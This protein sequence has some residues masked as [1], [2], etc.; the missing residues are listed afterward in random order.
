MKLIDLTHLIEPGMPVF[1]GTESPILMGAN[2]VERNGF[3]EKKLTLYSHTG[4]HMDAPAHMQAGGKTLD[5]YAV[6]D[7]FGPAVLADFSRTSLQTIESEHLAPYENA[8]RQAQFLILRT[9][10]AR[11]W[12]KPKYFAQFPALSPEAAAHVIG[13]G[14]KGVGIDAISIDHMEDTHFPVHHL[15]FN[16][17]M[18]II[19][20]LTHLEQV[21]T[22]FTLGCFPMLIQDA[23]GAPARAV[24]ILD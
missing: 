2:T 9:G 8:L 21:T 13:L 5:A 15:F 1:P 11:H 19:E 20:N 23:D 4:T 12:G 24:A 10:W 22:Q 17:G 14:I 16:A 3:A 18:F 6:A 7:F